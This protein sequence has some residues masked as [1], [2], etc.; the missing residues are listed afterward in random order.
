MSTHTD[1][2]ALR[3]RLQAHL[4]DALKIEHATIPPYLTA[5]LSIHEGTNLEASEIIRSVLLEEMLHLTLVANL[6]NSIG[7]QPRLTDPGFVLAYPAKLPHTAAAF[8]VSIEKFAP[9]AIDTFLKIERPEKRGA[10]PQPDHYTTLGQFYKSIRLQFAELRRRYKNNEGDVFTGRRDRQVAPSHYYGSGRIVEVVDFAT[11]DAALSEIIEQGEGSERSIYDRD[12]SITGGTGREPAHYFRFMEIKKAHVYRGGRQGRRGKPHGAAFPVDFTAVYPIRSNTRLTDYPAGSPVREALEAFADTYG[13]LLASL[14]E[15]FNGNPGRLQHAVG[16]MFT[17]KYQAQALMRTPSG[18][19]GL[20]VGPTFEQGQ[21]DRKDK[22]AAPQEISSAPGGPDPYPAIDRVIAGHARAFRK[23]GVLTVRPGYEVTGGLLTR[24][25]AIVVT[26][27]RKRNVARADALPAEIDGYPVDVREASAQKRTRVEDPKRFVAERHADRRITEH[28]YERDAQTGK[29]LKPL[30]EPDRDSKKRKLTYTAP[31]GASLTPM[32]GEMTIVC[33]ASPDAG[34]TQLRKFLSDVR[35]QLTVG[36]YDFCSKQVLDALLTGLR[37]QQK[38]SLVLDRP[39]TLSASA[40]QTDD[41]ARRTLASSL[42]PRLTFAWAAEAYDQMV[43]GWIYP[44]AYHIKVAVKDHESVW[45]SSGNWNP[46]NQPAIDPFGKMSAAQR[47]KMLETVQHSDRDWHVIVT[48]PGIARTFEAYLQHDL[49]VASTVQAD[50]T[51]SPQKAQK[52]GQA[53]VE[54]DWTP[55]FEP[56]TIKGTITVHPLLTPDTG[57]GDYVNAMLALI[58][59]ARTR[60]YIQTQ[61]MELPLGPE[62]QTGVAA[63]I[64]AVQAKIK[65]GLDVRV[66]VS[67]WETGEQTDYLERLQ[68]AGFDVSKMRIQ[69]GVHNKGFVVDSKIVAVGSQNWSSEGVL[70]NRDA[71]V[72]VHDARAAKYFEKIF[73]HDWETLAKPAHAPAV[74]AVTGTGAGAGV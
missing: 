65:D 10:P 29:P 38:V 21:R 7:G 48:H 62:S 47:K 6:L 13:D 3:Q 19:P 12:P 51:P 54:A 43:D 18:K 15:A 23:P 24:Q 31:P 40:N 14:E 53:S 66:I 32:T 11:A 9:A 37:G 71:T 70:Q 16:T 17:L 27:R 74:P 20:T 58:Q 73:L 59:S 36:M 33:H 68:H 46:S 61:Y 2:T 60:L 57:S 52:E 25:P 39:G 41:V 30:P 64:Q 22:P 50:V 69:T 34:F 55:D 5:W 42:G 72:I 56:L 45:L 67:Q 26:V 44:S 8:K 28:P 35:S 49:Q 1:V 4:Q 63:L